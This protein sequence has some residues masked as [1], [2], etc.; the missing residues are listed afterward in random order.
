MANDF[1]D[2]YS[3]ALLSGGAAGFISNS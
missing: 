3:A 2:F 1:A